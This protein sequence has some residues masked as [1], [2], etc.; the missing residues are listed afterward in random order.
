MALIDVNELLDDPD[1]CDPLTF[2]RRTQVVGNNG[3]A[4]FTTIAG[5][6]IVGSVQPGGPD[7]LARVPNAANP[8]QWIRVYTATILIPHDE[9]LGIYGDV[10]NWSGKRYQVRTADD[11]SQYGAGYSKV[12]AEMILEGAPA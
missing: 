1:F 3:L 6:S 5:I 7:L 10:L 4:T 12:F 2:D 8:S 11:W 9:A